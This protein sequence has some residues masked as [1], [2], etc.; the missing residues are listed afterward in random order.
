MVVHVPRRGFGM[1]DRHT[2]LTDLNSELMLNIKHGGQN[3]RYR[4][5]RRRLYVLWSKKQTQKNGCKVTQPAEFI[6]NSL[7][8]NLSRIIRVRP[9]SPTVRWLFGYI[10]ASYP[11]TISHSEKKIKETRNSLYTFRLRLWR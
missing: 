8:W 9:K 11:S 4:A 7:I 1:K 10:E 5:E 3:Q 6:Q 2:M